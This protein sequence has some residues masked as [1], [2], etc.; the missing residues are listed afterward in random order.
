[1]KISGYIGYILSIYHVSEKVETIYSKIYRLIEISVNIGEY[2]RYNGDI[3]L[4]TDITTI[5]VK[6]WL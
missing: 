4:I 6:N 2:R 5:Q 1:M 3:S